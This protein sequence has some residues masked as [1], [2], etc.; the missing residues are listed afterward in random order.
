MQSN[1]EPVGTI[2]QQ[3]LDGQADI[4]SGQERLEHCHERLLLRVDQAENTALNAIRSSA[5]L[6]H[7]VRGNLQQQELKILHVED[8]QV[9]NEGK[10]DR[11]LREVGELRRSVNDVHSQFSALGRELLA[12]MNGTFCHGSQ[13]FPLF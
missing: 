3:L 13:Y 8:D 5:N 10:M 6:G 2:L 12:K 1:L 7:E 4:R 11:L 9:M